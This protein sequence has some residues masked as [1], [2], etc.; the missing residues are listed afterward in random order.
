[1]LDIPLL[2]GAAPQTPPRTWR[3]VRPDAAEL[4]A[5]RRMRH[6]VFVEHQGIFDSTDLDWAD[7][8]ARTVV[9]VAVT[10]D[11][12]VLGGVRLTPHDDGPDIGWWK[13]DRLVVRPDAQHVRGIGTALVRRA[14]TTAEQLGVLRFDAT[15]QA[16]N[17][18]MFTQLGWETTGHG[19]FFGVP[20][21]SMRWPLHRVR[22]LLAATKQ[23][24]GQLLSVF[25]VLSGGPDGSASLGG[26]GFVGDDGAPVPGSDLVAACDAILPAMV[27]A[28]PRWAG[29]CSVLVNLNDLSAMG[30]EPV[31]LLDSVAG[32][33]GVDVGR[34]LQGMADAAAAWGVP[35]LGGHTQ[36]G[37]A[38][39]LSVTA[40]GRTDRPVPGGGG[41]IGDD[42]SLTVDLAGRWR[43]GFEGRQWDS[44]SFRTGEELRHLGGLVADARPSAAKDVSMAGIVGTS[45]MLAEASG[46]GVTLDVSAIPRPDGTTAGDWMTCFPGFGMLTADAPGTGRMGS[47]LAETAVIGRLT[48]E[49]GVR[50]RWPDGE[51]T[52]I[53]TTVTGLG[54][55]TAVRAGEH[56]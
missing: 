2:T 40:L 47:P 17:E 21:V 31:G 20:H 14:C 1:M 48:R 43:P 54:K 3:I 41:S 35:V 10:G 25:S 34:V 50:F 16:A 23:P 22:D 24:L 55:V 49:P 26:A 30:A 32:Y 8:D 46:T 15:V 44:T 45:G 29:W 11:G 37:A 27:D 19:L 5:Y 18:D 51:E 12:S 9:L 38:P 33:D 6:E 39:S 36:T 13:G 53:A 56:G 52:E 7:E 42:L 4:M 28:D